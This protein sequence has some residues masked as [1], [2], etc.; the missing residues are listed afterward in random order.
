[1]GGRGEL[2]GEEGEEVFEGGR[3]GGGDG[4]TAGVGGANPLPLGGGGGRRSARGKAGGGGGGG[5]GLAGRLCGAVAVVEI[6]C[7]GGVGGEA[8]L[9]GVVG[10]EDLREGLDD[11]GERVGG[12]EADAAGAGGFEVVDAL[13]DLGAGHPDVELSEGGVRSLGDGGE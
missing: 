11:L 10:L 13:G 8:R 5:G 1:G 3:G 7:A 6:R 9:V 12:E 4:L 2:V